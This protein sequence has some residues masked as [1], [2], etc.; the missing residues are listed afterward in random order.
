MHE[1]NKTGDRR[2]ELPDDVGGREHHAESHLAGDDATFLAWLDFSAYNLSE[3]QL[4]KILIDGGV[5]LNNGSKFG[6]GGDGYFRLNFGCPR[7]IL[8]EGLIKIEK[9]LNKR[10]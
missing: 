9:A 3:K 1:I 5:A 7:A 4:G 8:E 10:E 6:T 2:V